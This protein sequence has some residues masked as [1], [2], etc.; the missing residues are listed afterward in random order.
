MNYRGVTYFILLIVV[1]EQLSNIFAAATPVMK[2]H[3]SF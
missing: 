3:K 2:S 1:K